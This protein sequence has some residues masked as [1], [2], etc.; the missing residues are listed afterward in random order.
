MKNK[1]LIAVG[2][3]GI[4]DTVILSTLANIANVGVLLPGIIGF[5]LVLLGINSEYR[6]VNLSLNSKR[7]G[8]FFKILFMVWILS[9]VI[10]ESILIFSSRSEEKAD[11]DYLMILG[12]GVHGKELSLTLLERMEKGITYL[13]DNPKVSV[14]V[15]GGRG[16]GEEITE[17]EA[18]KRYLVDH[19]I[20]EYRIITEEK[21]TS[22]MENFKYTKKILLKKTNRKLRILIVT[23]DFHIPRAKLLAKRNGFIP[24]GMPSKTHWSIL[25]NCYIREYFAVLKSL[26]IDR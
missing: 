5:I 20:E 11:V 10:I 14:I 16:V 6:I 25:L 17:A 22:T 26:V 21:S 13:K 15:S 2:I 23:N 19:G 4:L 18:M 8:I 24:Y 7:I 9:F 12:A 3:I 1:I